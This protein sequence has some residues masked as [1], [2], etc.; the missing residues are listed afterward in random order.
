MAVE[1][2]QAKAKP[3]LSTANVPQIQYNRSGRL[4]EPE[5]KNG[6]ANSQVSPILT[7]Q[8]SAKPKTQ[9]TNLD[10]TIDRGPTGSEPIQP[11]VRCSFSWLTN[12]GPAPIA[13][14]SGIIISDILCIA[15]C[16][17]SYPNL[18]S[19]CKTKPAAHSAINKGASCLASL[20]SSHDQYDRTWPASGA[21][22]GR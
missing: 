18:H 10:N 9:M 13:N 4:I 15:A 12:I 16:S 7:I 14:R 5:V 22:N 8:E 3:K 2:F 1:N 19:K 11:N 20:N 6:G 17:C 21:A